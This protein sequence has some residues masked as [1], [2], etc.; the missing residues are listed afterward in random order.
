MDNVLIQNF[1]SIFPIWHVVA[2]EVIERLAVIWIEKM[3]QFMENN[4][5]DT[6]D[7]CF[8]KIEVKNDRSAFYSAASPHSCHFSNKD[9]RSWDS[10]LLNDRIPII[11]ALV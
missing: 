10:I 11:D 8:E 4:I 6:C 5:V 2:Q 3:R 9:F 7:P 1:F